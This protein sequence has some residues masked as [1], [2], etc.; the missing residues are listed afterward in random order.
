MK[1]LIKVFIVLIIPVTLYGCLGRACEG[2]DG[3]LIH[4]IEYSSKEL[5]NAKIYD[6]DPITEAVIDSSIGGSPNYLNSTSFRIVFDKSFFEPGH[7]VLVKTDS[8]THFISDI[9]INEK[10]CNSRILSRDDYFNILGSYKSDISL[11]RFPNGMPNQ[12]EIISK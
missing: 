6:L 10:V 8:T 12:I 3:R 5:Q 4:F 11:V 1:L 7:L 9:I 2:Y